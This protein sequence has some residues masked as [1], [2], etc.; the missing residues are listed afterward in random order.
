M[1][2]SRTKE[3]GNIRYIHIH[4]RTQK[5]FVLDAVEKGREGRRSEQIEKKGQCSVGRCTEVRVGYYVNFNAI[6]PR[7]CSVL[8]VTV[9]HPPFCGPLFANTYEIMPVGLFSLHPPHFRPFKRITLDICNS[10]VLRR[11][12]CIVISARND[13]GNERRR[14]VNA[15][16]TFAFAPLLFPLHA[17]MLTNSKRKIK[18]TKLRAKVRIVCSPRERV[19][20]IR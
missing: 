13:G 5:P 16:K 1:R 17:C 6:P 2:I 8:P 19:H 9:L 20:V 3:K 4:T 7:L 12:V 11:I 15:L 10:R 14:R 18:R